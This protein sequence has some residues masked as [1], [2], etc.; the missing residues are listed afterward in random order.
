MQY[1]DE[2]FTREDPL[3]ESPTAIS[4]DKSKKGMSARYPT[5]NL[6]P[7]FTYAPTNSYEH[8]ENVEVNQ[9]K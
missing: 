5:E 2:D 3:K 4:P 6:F 1:F 7:D 8:N 9:V